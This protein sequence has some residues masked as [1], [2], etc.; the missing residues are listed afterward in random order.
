MIQSEYAFTVLYSSGIINQIYGKEHLF[1]KYIVFINVNMLS[2]AHYLL[3][4]IYAIACKT[5]SLNFQL[6]LQCNR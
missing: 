6:I 4:Y 5:V 3:W 2:I 1:F